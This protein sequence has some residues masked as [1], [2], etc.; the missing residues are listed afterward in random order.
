[1]NKI[2][3]VLIIGINLADSGSTG[4]IMRNSLEYAARNGNYDYSVVVPQNK[5]NLNTYGYAD[6]KLSIASRIIYHKLLKQYRNPDGFFETPYTK[7][8][9]RF[10]NSKSRQYKKCFVHLHNIHMCKVDLRM[11]F[12]YLSKEKNVQKL[13]YTLHDEW[14][15]T[16]GCYCASFTHCNKWKIGC[17]GECPQNYGFSGFKTSKQWKLKE[18]YTLLLK[19]KLILV[20]VSKWIQNNIKESFFKTIPTYVNYGETSINPNKIDSKKISKIKQK[21]NFRNKKIVLSVSA[22]WNEWKGLKYL[23]QIAEKIPENYQLLVIGGKIKNHAKIIHIETLQ[24]DE[25]PNYYALADVYLSVSQCESL[26]LTTCEAQICGTPV[27]A[28]GHTAIK[29]T[30]TDKTGVIVGEENNVEKM[31][32]TIK[33]VVEKKPFKKEDIIENGNRFKKYEHSKRMFKIYEDNK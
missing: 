14:P 10:I 28:F 27:V 4:S 15:Y 19:N 21:Y 3:K 29:E 31:I 23:Y 26:G 5:G 18:K 2:N 32:D 33:Y 12:K 1:M 16:G 24:Q 9:I 30:I 8:I 20:S 11:L 6:K 17:K 22:Y 25:L 7:R 13:F